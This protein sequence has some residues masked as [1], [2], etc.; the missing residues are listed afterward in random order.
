MFLEFR[1]GERPATIVR[2]LRESS[3]LDRVSDDQVRTVARA[4]VNEQS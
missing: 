3:S 4:Q 2:T 1:F